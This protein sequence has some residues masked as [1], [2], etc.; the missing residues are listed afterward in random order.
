MASKARQPARSCPRHGAEEQQLQAGQVDAL[1]PAGRLTSNQI[2]VSD[3]ITV[4]SVL[5]IVPHYANTN[6][7][8]PVHFIIVVFTLG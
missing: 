2:R 5:G 6:G 7:R 8:E 4:W 3:W 1:F